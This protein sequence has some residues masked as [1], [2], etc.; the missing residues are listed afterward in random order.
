MAQPPTGAADLHV[1]EGKLSQ[2]ASWS[3]GLFISNSGFS[4]EGLEA[5]GKGKRLVCM[6]GYDLSEM[7][8][9]QLSIVDVLERK[10]RRAAETGR[11]YISIR[12]L[13]S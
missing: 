5:F 3:R 11:P 2:K 10:V 8:N 6:D 13:F 12:E 9:K 4:P 7:L 1:F